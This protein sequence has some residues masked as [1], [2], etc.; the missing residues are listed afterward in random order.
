[1]TFKHKLSKR[2]AISRPLLFASLLLGSFACTEGRTREFLSPA[3]G[4]TNNTLVTITVSPRVASAKPGETISFSAKGTTVQG[5]TIPADVQWEATGGTIGADGTFTSDRH[6]LFS[7]RARST[8]Q[9]GLADSASVA[10][11]VSPKDILRVRLSPDSTELY[12]GDGLQLDA[13]AQ[14]ADG[15]TVQSPPLDWSASGGSVD[16]SG[17]YAPAA[18]GTYTVSAS[19]ASGVIGQATVV[20]LRTQRTLEGF[21]LSPRTATITMG[22]SRQFQLVAK[23]SDG[24]TTPFMPYWSATGGAITSD[25]LFEAGSAAGNFKVIAFYGIAADTAFVSITEPTISQLDI[26][27]TSVE[28]APAASQQYVATAT[29]SDGSTRSAGVA[30]KVTGG[31]IT[32]GGLY[33]APT[34]KGAYKVIGSVAGT[35]LADTSIVTVTQ[36]L[37]AQTQLLLNPSTATV[38]VGTTRQFSVTARYS[39]GTTS[40]PSV[41]W[42]ATGGSVTAG[43]LYAAGA[44]AGTFRVIARD[45][46]S[47][48]A[49]TSAVTVTAAVLTQVVLDPPAFTVRTGLGQQLSVTAKW[50]DGTTAAPSA[51]YDATAGSASTSTTP[52]GVTYKATGGTVSAAGL[53]VAGTTPGTYRVIAAA[54]GGSPADTSFAT[55]TAPAPVMN[56]LTLSPGSSSLRPGGSQQFTVRGTWSDGSTSVPP[57]TWEATGGIISSSGLYKAGPAEGSFRVIATQE[58]GTLADTSAVTVAAAAPVL[59]SVVLTPATVSLQAGGTRQ[60]AVSGTWSDGSTASPSVVYTATGGTI[61]NGGLYVSGNTAGTYRV[62]ATQAGGSLADTSAVTIT[63]APTLTALSIAPGSVALQTGKGQQF[64]VTGTYSNGS[65]GTPAVT[66]K[67]TGGSISNAGWYT[68]GNTAGAF[69]VI[70]SCACGVAD[71]AAISLSASDL[72]GISIT[73]TSADLKTG[74]QFTFVAQGWVQGSNTPVTPS[75]TWSATGG[76][77]TQGGVYTAGSTAGTFYVKAVSNTGSPK[78]SATVNIASA[79][80]PPPAPTL[81]NIELTPASVTLLPGDVQ[82]FQALGRMTDGSTIP[83]SVTYSQT[84]GTMSGSTY[85]AGSQSGTYRVIAA[86]VAG[87]FADTATVVIGSTPPPPQNDSIEPAGFIKVYDNPMSDPLTSKP[88]AY[89]FKGFDDPHKGFPTQY[90]N[91]K[92]V[93]EAGPVGTPLT[94]YRHM[95]P[96]G[97]ELAGGSPLRYLAG[98][99][100]PN[101]GSLYVRMWWRGSANWTYNGNYQLKFLWPRNNSVDLN[102]E[103]GFI[104]GDA[105]DP[106]FYF[107]VATQSTWQTMSWTSKKA[108]VYLDR[109]RWYLLEWL[110]RPNTPGAPDGS[111]QVAIDGVLRWTQPG[112]MW[113]GAGQTPRWDYLW[114]DPTYSIG[115]NPVPDFDIWFDVKQWYTS[116]R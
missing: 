59:Q 113:F 101:T 88:N 13:T 57:A 115:N 34:Q 27:P 58:G 67:A 94:L 6:G 43:G 103:F 62:V 5:K 46:A 60:Y 75:V 45:P 102:H 85:T 20:V 100:G 116:I 47:G 87:S 41:T 31:T 65:K 99:F 61:T 33:Y 63:A 111:I 1:M 15:T 11:F 52:P 21:I 114:V 90:Y 72:V 86:Q 16:G 17:W 38:P 104:R 79:V 110:I 76:S 10:V 12:E 83:V 7:V 48:K 54:A 32:A 98:T 95:F 109:G 39:D 96:A 8:I 56:A 35:Q 19:A 68:A 55:V 25:G 26:S 84:G 14:L 3:P 82:A 107:H 73:P 69:L 29:M 106:R 40:T 91:V 93:E 28:L 22:A 23:W 51:G 74:E 42:S 64:S 81:K 36:T 108:G 92:V 89:G 2:L 70:A 71:T 97:T 112:I 50:S 30:W 18:E 24:T 49:D 77:V 78:D 44:T 53:Y 4:Q 105:T 66:W 80:A 9:P 37:A